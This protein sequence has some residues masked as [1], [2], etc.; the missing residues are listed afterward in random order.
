MNRSVSLQTDIRKPFLS[1]SGTLNHFCFIY[2]FLFFS[3]F[4]ILLLSK[5][6]EIESGENEFLHKIRQRNEK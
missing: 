5:K 1:F 2:Y 6:L 4:F 3:S